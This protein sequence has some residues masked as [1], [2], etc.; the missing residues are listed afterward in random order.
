MRLQRIRQ[1]WALLLVIGLIGFSPV[2][3]QA[4]ADEELLTPIERLN[5]SMKGIQ[6]N[7]QNAKIKLR[8]GMAGVAGT[9]DKPDQRQPTPAESCC[10]GNIERM[11]Q[12]IKE[13]VRTL[14]E[15]DV[16]YADR[17][18]TIALEQLIEVRGELAVIAR[19]VAVFRMSGSTDSA[20]QAL[21]G[22]IHPFNRLRESV[23]ALEKCCPI[24]VP[25]H[26]GRTK[27]ESTP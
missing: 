25:Q 24:E 6:A 4:V 18:D 15:L 20:G 8:H 22:I 21:L 7:V 11:N 16:Y 27:T 14:E 13:M 17:A 2:Y 3:A 26:S 19:G 12:R 1:I 10:S 23:I 9:G 5:K